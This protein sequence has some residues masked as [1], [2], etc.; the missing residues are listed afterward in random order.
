MCS[1]S[2]GI[3]ALNTTTTNSNWELLKC[4]FHTKGSL[5]FWNINV[6]MMQL[7]V[8]W[9]HSIRLTNL[10]NLSLCNSKINYVYNIFHST[11]Y[12]QLPQALTRITC[13][14]LDLISLPLFYLQ[15]KVHVHNF[16]L[17]FYTNTNTSTISDRSHN[18]VGVWEQLNKG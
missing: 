9:C 5:S 3:D 2:D 17:R 18:M 11:I 13:L 7:V 8:E 6:A 10:V 16:I 14:H 1:I 4:I 12:L 15:I